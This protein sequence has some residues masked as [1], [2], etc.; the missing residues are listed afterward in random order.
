MFLKNRKRYRKNP[1]YPFYKRSGMYLASIV[2]LF[3]S[4]GILTTVQPAYRISSQAV[5]EWTSDIESAT[6][7]Y[8]IGLENRAFKQ[9]YPEDKTLPKLSTTLF[10]LATS[11]KPN[12]PRSLLG[13]ELPGFST[14]DSR[15][16]IAGKGTNYTNL[17]IESSPP[18][19]EVLKDREA[20]DDVAEEEITEKEIKDNI[21]TTGDRNVV[22]IYNSHNRESFLPHLPGVKDPDL[23]H[24]KEVNITK[25]SDRLAKSMEANGIGTIVDDT[26][27]MSI[28]KDKDWTYGRS[29]DASRD[30]V[31]EAF[32]SNKEI[33]YVF[34]LH[35]DSIPYE[36]T[37]KEINGEMY[38]R[39]MIVV[40]AEHPDYE[41][42]LGLAAELHYLLEEKY[43]G[44]SRG[45]YPKEGPGTNGVFNQDL[46]ENSLILEFGGVEN[47]LDELYRSAD[48]LADVFSEFYWDAEKVDANP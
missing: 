36:K 46:S 3:I 30:V 19:E 8:L 17:S 38:G 48:A 27:I 18:L 2:L 35:R 26:D 43:P 28:L 47:N 7:L 11:V 4:I 33:Q 40:G 42:N 21:P 6:F 41:K 44:L 37:T 9:A 45:V 23:A 39:I 34:D 31:Q 29:Y 13:N 24:H 25:V 22:Y 20:I 10:H 14:F 32:S 5:T 12:D 1:L 15:L 16:L